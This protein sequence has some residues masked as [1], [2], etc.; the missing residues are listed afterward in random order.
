[1]NTLEKYAAKRRLIE[2]L[3]H[4]LKT[5]GPTKMWGGQPASWGRTILNKLTMSPSNYKAYQ[6]GWDAPAQRAVSKA[7]WAAAKDASGTPVSNRAG[8]S[9]F[10]NT[11]F[12]RDPS[13]AVQ[14]AP[15][16]SAPSP[17]RG[18]RGHPGAPTITSL[19]PS[20]KLTMSPKERRQ[21]LEIVNR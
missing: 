10:T 11:S 21:F 5:A 18:L 19:P 16:R 7:G 17:S 6:S 8:A 9:R 15:P 1:M 12:A 2:R 20:G 4:K 3:S 14:P 13:I